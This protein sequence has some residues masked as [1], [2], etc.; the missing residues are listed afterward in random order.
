MR[1]SLSSLF[2]NK[3]L[4]FG[5]VG[6]IG[7]FIEAS[8][9]SYFATQPDIGPIYGRCISFPV[10]VFTTWILNRKMTFQS[11]NSPGAESLKYLVVQTIGAFCNLALFYVLVSSWKY[12][13]KEP[14]LP[15][16]LAATLGFAVN[17][18]LSKKLVFK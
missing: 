4:R 10:A 12:L 6:L 3:L 8:L 18:L 1:Y 11:S 9:L 7:F 16:F 15:L 14:V 5:V 17:F 13:A 2:K